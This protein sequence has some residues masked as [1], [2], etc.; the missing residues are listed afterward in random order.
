MSQPMHNRDSDFEELQPTGEASH[1][2]DQ[3]LDDG[4]EGIPSRQRVATTT[5]G[6]PDDP[7]TTDGEC[8][9][10]G[11]SLPDRLTSITTGII[12]VL[13]IFAVIRFAARTT[14]KSNRN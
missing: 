12:L 11:S 9:S 3:R 13:L 4:C 7:S 10:C 2:P 6:Y 14:G 5:G 1:I 8:R